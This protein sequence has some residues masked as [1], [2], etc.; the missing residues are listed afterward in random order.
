MSNQQPDS[1]IHEQ[2]SAAFLPLIST[3][4]SANLDSLLQEDNNHEKGRCFKTE[5]P[6]LKTVP[7]CG[8]CAKKRRFG[9]MS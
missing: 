9:Y 1:E 8:F 2:T 5:P 4:A 3:G 6:S 7:P